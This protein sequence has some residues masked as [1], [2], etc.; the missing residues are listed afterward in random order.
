MNVIKTEIDGM[1][2]IEPRIFTIVSYKIII[3][4]YFYAAL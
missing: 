4:K 2:I 3:C 1:V